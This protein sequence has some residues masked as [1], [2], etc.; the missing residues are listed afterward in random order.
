VVFPLEKLIVE[1]LLLALKAIGTACAVW[2]VGWLVGQVV[3]YMVTKLLGKIGLDEWMRRL[4]VGR[5]IRR[6][7]YSAHEFMGILA[8]WL[9][10]AIF[11]VLGIYASG[12]VA[13]WEDLTL[14]AYTA[15]VVYIGGFIKLLLIVIA[16]FI[17]ADVFVGY[18]YRSTELRSEMQMLYP[19]AE[20]LRIVLYIAIVVFG[21]EQSGLG[22]GVLPQLLQPII[23]GVTAIVVLF[24]VYL[25]VQST[26]APRQPV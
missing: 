14:Y 13:G 25:I 22:V 11:G 2:I 3:K 18:I 19:L 20:Y 23:W 17:L 8:A 10:Y 9:M 1:V 4:S 21:V 5:A 6:T 24:M 12:Y 16:G 26:K 7:G 15:L